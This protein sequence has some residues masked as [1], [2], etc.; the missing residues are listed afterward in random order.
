MPQP[1]EELRE[2]KIIE[3]AERIVIDYANFSGRESAH[4][5][6]FRE[7]TINNLRSLLTSQ[8]QALKE[9]ILSVIGSTV[10][11]YHHENEKIERTIAHEIYELVS[12]VFNQ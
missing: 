9:K 4:R 3:T 6:E 10:E 12:Q 8:Q 2:D 1:N 11:A 7:K 5:A